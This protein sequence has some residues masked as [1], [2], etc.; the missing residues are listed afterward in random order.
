MPHKRPIVNPKQYSCEDPGEGVAEEEI[1]EGA[2][3]GE[4]EE[5]W[6]TLCDEYKDKFRVEQRPMSEVFLISYHNQ[7]GPYIELAPSRNP[8]NR[9]QEKAIHNLHPTVV[10]VRMMTRYI[11]CHIGEIPDYRNILYGNGK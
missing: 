4:D 5:D 8:R 2:V 9:L 11:N 1:R 10:I 7:K 3:G 6:Y